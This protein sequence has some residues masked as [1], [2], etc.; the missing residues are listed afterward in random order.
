MA[1]FRKLFPVLA[2]VGMMFMATSASA[3]TFSCNGNAGVPPIVRAEGLTEL[4]GDLVLNCTGGIVTVAG[5]A[6]PQVNVQIFLNTNVTSRLTDTS[7]AGG[8]YNEALLMIDDPAPAQQ[9]LCANSGL[10]CS[11]PGTGAVGSPGVAGG[12]NYAGAG[13]S[14]N[15]FQ[16]QATG[17]NSVVWLGVPVDPPGSTGTRIIRIVNV[18]A[19]ANQLGVSSTLIPTQIVMF[20]S[21]TG[22]SSIPIN[23]P[24]QTVAFIQ[25]GLTTSVTNLSGSGKTLLQCVSENRD[26]ATDSSKAMQTGLTSYI[27]F[28]EGFASSFKRR[29]VNLGSSGDVSPTPLAQ[30][31][32]GAIYSTES[33]FY[34][35]TFTTHNGGGKQG[36]ADQGTRV[37]AKFSNIPAGVALYTNAYRIDVGG[38]L[39][40]TYRDSTIGVADQ[41]LVARLVTTDSNGNGSFSASTITGAG[42]STGCGSFCGSAGSANLVPLTISN[43]SATAV[44][45]VMNSNPLAG[46]SLRFPV[47]FAYTANTSANLPGLGTP[48]VNLSFAPTST[49]TTADRTSSLPRFA[50]TSV[51]RNL[52]AVNSCTTNI[53][54]PFLTN[55][56]GFDSGVAISNT[57]VDPF[58][59]APQAGTCKINYYG[60]TTGGGAAPAAQTSGVVAA[61]KQLLFTLSSGGNLGMAATPGF[62]GYSIAQCGFQYAHGF[63]YISDVGSTKVSE[64]YLALILDGG[65]G[66]RT[67]F[68][69]EI[70]G[71]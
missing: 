59:T 57:S 50:D 62:Q 25:T 34:N 44:W 4:V 7:A 52:Q 33:G 68:L 6:V 55:Q 24:Q 51:S 29:N 9:R 32:P 11:I 16:G 71:H 21:A 23:N 2:V 5:V 19:N 26:L 56:L 49:V 37:M 46:E 63:A 64:A 14:L 70:L 12:V 20:I 48:T 1:D 22:T 69:S 61:G 3:Q 13:G 15:V 54:F 67:P 43:G 66:A 65:L 8:S 38:G 10:A 39:P 28:T 45:E 35:D 41:T 36:L 58:G 30:N 40:S 31:T 42:T 47:V 17:A 53:L 18:R 60:E 27:S